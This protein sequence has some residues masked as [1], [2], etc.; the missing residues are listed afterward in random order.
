MKDKHRKKQQEVK[1]EL[2]AL[3]PFLHQIKDKDNAFKVPEGYFS[4][5][6]AQ[7]LDQM[8]AMPEASPKVN[9]KWRTN[10]SIQHFI[11]QLAV[12]L[13][14]RMALALA[15]VL[16]I[17]VAAWFIVRSGEN[18]VTAEPSFATLSV[19][20]IQK[21]IDANLD[22]FDEEMVKE[23]AQEHNNL[24]IIPSNT[25]ETE[26]LDLYLDQVIDQLDPKEL[27]ELF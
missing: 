7:M 9:R 14:P 10:I 3:S 5:F 11:D 19:E 16:V 20:E 2:K 17:V 4:Q 24:S 8:K 21:Y 23:I 12:L 13:Q 25:L 22:D 18:P 26:E 27:E 15:S 1:E 6:Q